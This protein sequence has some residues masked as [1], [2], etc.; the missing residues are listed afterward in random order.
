MRPL[1]PRDVMTAALEG[2]GITTKG[3]P[4]A[5]VLWREIEVPVELVRSTFLAAGVTEPAA[6]GETANFIGRVVGAILAR[7]RYA[8]SLKA[9]ARERATKK[10][11]KRSQR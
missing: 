2:G 11:Q 3:M 1:T 7:D 5:R 8:A 6:E 4:V 9:K 10:R